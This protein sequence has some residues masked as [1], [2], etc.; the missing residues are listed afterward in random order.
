LANVFGDAKDDLKKIAKDELVPDDREAKE[1][2]DRAAAKTKYDAMVLKQIAYLNAQKT[3]YAKVAAAKEKPD[4]ISLKLD[5]Q[6]ER[7]NLDKALLD[8]NEARRGAGLKP[9]DASL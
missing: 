3:Y 4:D 8:Y 5:L 2:Q 1:V 9:V 6:I 7:V